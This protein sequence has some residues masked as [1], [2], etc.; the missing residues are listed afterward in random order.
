[1]KRYRATW[2]AS[3][4]VASGL[5][6]LIC[7]GVSAACWWQLGAQ[8][9]HD[10]L[11]WLA[12]LPLAL[13]LG[14]LP[15][16]VFGYTITREAI[17]VHRLLWDTKLPR[18]G[19]ESA[20]V[21]PEAMR[22]SLRTFGNGGGFSITG[23]YYNK[24]LGSYRAFVTDPRRCVVLRYANRRVVVSPDSPEEFVRELTPS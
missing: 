11:R 22:R 13:L 2:C 21:D 9:Q 19:L 15:F 7:L 6:T 1:M 17:L 12:A 24:R 3:L 18:A 4:T 20:Q 8:K 10:A 5:V 16:M 23:L 14:M